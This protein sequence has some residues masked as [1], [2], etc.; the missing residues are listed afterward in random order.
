[1][2]PSDLVAL[3]RNPDSQ[4]FAVI[5]CLQDWGIEVASVWV[6]KG[7]SINIRNWD[8]RGEN[9]EWDVAAYLDEAAAKVVAEELNTFLIASGVFIGCP[10]LGPGARR[11]RNP[12]DPNSTIG[13]YGSRHYVLEVP[14]RAE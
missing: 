11:V 1:M 7:Q 13:I 12:R 10:A 8:E 9:E 2:L 4:N 5:D 6:V 3:L 14:L